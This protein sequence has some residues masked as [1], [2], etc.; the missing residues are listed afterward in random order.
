MS[1]SRLVMCGV[2]DRSA[3]PSVLTWVSVCVLAVAFFKCH[4]FG[5]IPIG[6][7]SKTP[8]GVAIVSTV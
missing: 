5:A 4:L 3:D 8:D 2:P 7:S 6:F 1:L